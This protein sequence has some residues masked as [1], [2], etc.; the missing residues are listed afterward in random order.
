MGLSGRLMDCWA[1]MSESFGI[2]LGNGEPAHQME[3][4]FMMIEE[5]MQEEF[6]AGRAEGKTEGERNSLT[7][8]VLDILEI[9]NIKT[10]AVET[11]VKE[12]DSTEILRN[13]YRFAVNCTNAEEFLKNFQ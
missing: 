10:D 2:V 7:T 12:T 11:L 8:A 3:E 9:R 13:M 5:L 1:L 6:E 4:R